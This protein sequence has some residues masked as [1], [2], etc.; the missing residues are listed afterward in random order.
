MAESCQEEWLILRLPRHLIAYLQRWAAEDEVTVSAV[1]EEA[2]AKLCADLEAGR[3]KRVQ[4]APAK[5]ESA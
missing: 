3:T 5:K 2:V 4:Q 1:V